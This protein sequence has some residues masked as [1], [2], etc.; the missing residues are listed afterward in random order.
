M[1]VHMSSGTKAAIAKAGT[2]SFAPPSSWRA[3]PAAPAVGRQPAHPAPP[4][5][6]VASPWPAHPAART[7]MASGSA[8]ALADDGLGGILSRAAAAE[9]SHWHP[10]AA[11]SSHGREAMSS[12]SSSGALPTVRK[13]TGGRLP[14]PGGA[15]QA[16][17]PSK[18]DKTYDFQSRWLA[19]ERKEQLPFTNMPN[20][21]DKL[22]ARS[23]STPDLQSRFHS[24]AVPSQGFHPEALPPL[25]PGRVQHMR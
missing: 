3:A 18:N 23:V 13:T 9:G 5:S 11:P 10:N 16:N 20:G 4:K 22:G 15:K 7:A 14:E 8:A 17:L 19:K 6:Q 12:S 2:G 25:Q 1:V 24:T 21:P